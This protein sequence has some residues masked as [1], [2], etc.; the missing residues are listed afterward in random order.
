MRRALP[1]VLWGAFVLLVVGAGMVLLRACGL[2]LPLGWNFCVAETEAF[3]PDTERSAELEREVGRLQA[4]LLRRTLDCASIPPPPPPPLELPK[5]AGPPKPQQ[6]AELKAPPPTLPAD[7]WDKKDVSL[8]KGCWQLGRE[9]KTRWGGRDCIVRAGKMCFDA[10]GHGNRET[11]I[12]CPGAPPI[13]CVAPVTAK[14]GS[15]GS[16]GSTQ[17]EV[18]CK[19][20]PNRWYGPQNTLA[21]RRQTDTLATCHDQVGFD[22]EFRRLPD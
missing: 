4:E 18:E 17:P 20:P 14:F 7:R 16:L 19:P 11:T 9:G 1:A 21:C 5:E 15:D 10:D 13:R 8:L 3:V 6:T 22:H 12:E 2:A